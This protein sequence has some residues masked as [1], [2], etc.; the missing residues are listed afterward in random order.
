MSEEAI[1]KVKSKECLNCGTVYSQNDVISLN[2]PKE[3]QE[4]IRIQLSREKTAKR[5]KVE[6]W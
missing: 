4:R 3:E 5:E 6:R 1:N 2:M